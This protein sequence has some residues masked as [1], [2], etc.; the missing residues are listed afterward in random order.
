MKTHT[1]EGGLIIERLIHQTDDTELLRNAKLAA[2]YHHER[3]DGTG[4]PCGLKEINIPLQGRIVAIIDVY[5]ALLSERPYK[6]PFSEEEAMRIIQEG[7]GSHFDPY[8]TKVL[9]EI[10]DQLN[11]VREVYANTA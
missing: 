1:M 3:W 8:I 6:K 4:Y 5:D 10:R 7:M 11:E 2:V 9:V